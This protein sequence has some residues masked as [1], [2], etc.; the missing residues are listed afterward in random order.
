MKPA[1]TRERNFDR[2][3]FTGTMPEWADGGGPSDHNADAA[4]VAASHTGQP[5]NGRSPAV[6][7]DQAT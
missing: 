2:G 7:A 1:R 5:E 4:L 6:T 3:T